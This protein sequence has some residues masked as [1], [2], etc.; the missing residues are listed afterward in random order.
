M[1]YYSLLTL[2]Y[3]Y[4]YCNVAGDKKSFSHLFKLVK[5][6]SLKRSVFFLS[7]AKTESLRYFLIFA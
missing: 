2:C 5:H 6:G 1:N 3:N 7:L 4:V